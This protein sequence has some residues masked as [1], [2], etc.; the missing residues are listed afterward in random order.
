MNDL[1]KDKIC[2]ITGG[3]TGVGRAAAIKFAQQG[4][5]VIIA[6]RR[7]EKGEEV[8]KIIKDMGKEALYIKTDIS[9]EKQVE[10]LIDE[11]IRQYG[12]LDSAF[13]C[14]GIDGKKASLV[15]CDESNWD[16]IMNNNL[17][18]TFFLLKYE[19]KAMLKKK[20]AQL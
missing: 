1:L 4:A 9:Q 14:A 2:L 8:L 11:I 15:Q 5:T 3:G 7:V 20:R 12:R 6:N 16:E 13:N 10:K 18:S 19:I 17:K